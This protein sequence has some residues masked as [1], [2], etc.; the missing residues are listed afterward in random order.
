[1]SPRWAGEM[2]GSAPA[3]ISCV[4]FFFI[5]PHQG[6]KGETGI[7]GEQGIPGPPVCCEFTTLILLTNFTYTLDLYQRYVAGKTTKKNLI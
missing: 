5:F 6:L 3:L 2:S 7:S 1:M 4:V